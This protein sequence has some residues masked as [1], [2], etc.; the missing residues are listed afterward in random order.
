MFKRLSRIEQLLEKFKEDTDDKLNDIEKVLIL[1]ESNLKQHMQRSE[2]LE[3]IVDKMEETDLRPLRKH[4][5]MIEGGMKLVG[6][7]AILVGIAA[8][9]AKVLSLII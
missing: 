1:Q 9:V 5:A 6:V 8:G 4:V 2:H 3:K 7:I